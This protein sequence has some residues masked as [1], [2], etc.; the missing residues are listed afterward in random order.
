M[1]YFYTAGGKL[2]S[3]NHLLLF[4]RIQAKFVGA[5][6]HSNIASQCIKTLWVK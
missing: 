3:K 2:L 1:T 5:I 4:V 6:H